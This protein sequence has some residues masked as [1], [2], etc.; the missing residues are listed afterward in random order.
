M[1]KRNIKIIA[2]VVIATILAFSLVLGVLP[3]LL[4]GLSKKPLE[5]LP[6]TPETS[7]PTSCDMPYVLISIYKGDSKLPPQILSYVRDYFKQY[8]PEGQELTVCELPW[9]HSMFKGHV[10][11]AFPALAIKAENVSKTFMD[12]VGEKIGEKI[13]VIRYSLAVDLATRYGIP[14]QYS[15]EAKAE[16]VQGVTEYSRI[17]NETLASKLKYLLSLIAV[18][19]V[20]E[21]KLVEQ[22]QY[23]DIEAYPAVLY[24]SSKNISEQ[25]PYL[26]PYRGKYLIDPKYAL[27]LVGLISYTIGAQVYTELHGKKPEVGVVVGSSEA[28]ISLIVF[29]D[30]ACSYCAKL[31]NETLPKLDDLVREGRISINYAYSP[32]PHMMKEHATLQCY[33]KVTG[34]QEGYVE[35]VREL[36]SK[37]LKERKAATESEIKALELKASNGTLDFSEIEK[38]VNETGIKLVE[39]VFNEASEISVTATPTIIVWNNRENIG[40]I[41]EGYLPA[42]KLEEIIDNLLS[43]V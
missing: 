23:P 5:T 15:F 14:V 19:N 27:P 2:A 4:S 11:R 1:V 29:A 28:P 6:Q 31:V 35:I 25:L 13:Y 9:N 24:S 30:L 41:V 22:T 40:I 43:T 38:C 34:D 36:A 37:F 21:V 18:A 16:I 20:T 10:F 42:D 26:K 7:L 12:H 3:Y 17:D 39:E 32:S 8:I 33:L